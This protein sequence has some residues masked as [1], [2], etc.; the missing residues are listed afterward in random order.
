M[1]IRDSYRARNT[2]IQ[3]PG[4]AQSDADFSFYKEQYPTYSQQSNYIYPNENFALFAENI[5]YFNDDL[6]ITPGLRYENIITSTEGSYQKIN[7]DAAGNIIFNQTLNSE[8]SRQRSFIL[9]GVGLSYKLSPMFEIYGNGSQN[10]RSVT[11]ADISIIN[12]AF[13]INPNITDEKGYTIDLGIRGKIDKIVSLDINLFHIAYQD[14][15]GFIQKV[16]SDGSVKS[17]RGNVGN[18]DLNGLESLIDFNLS[19][20]LNFICGLASFNVKVGI[21]SE[22]GSSLVLSANCVTISF[23]SLIFSVESEPDTSIIAI[24]CPT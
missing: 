11:F 2:S 22:I 7:T 16:F 13:A 9:L 1:C 4:S 10:Y 18:A 24:V 15:I 5:F 21:G 17:E 14:R 23:G 12:P 20:L 8:E 6:S 19:E 3:G